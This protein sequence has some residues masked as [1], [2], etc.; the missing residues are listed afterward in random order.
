MGEKKCRRIGRKEKRP[1]LGR[2][3]IGVGATVFLLLC[4][5]LILPLICCVTVG[6][7]SYFISLNLSFP[8]KLRFPIPT[9]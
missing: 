2:E 4:L 7:A 9:S 6:E 1:Q 5:R 8:F 3:G